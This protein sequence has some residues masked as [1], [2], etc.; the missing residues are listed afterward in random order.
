MVI[1]ALLL[2]CL[3]CSLP[4]TAL[5][6]LTASLDKNP[7]MLGESVTLELTADGR[8]SA[9]SL[10]F[11]VLEQNFTV[12][13][14][15][16]SQST[17]IVNGVSTQQTTWKVV[18][19]P[20]KPG[21]FTIPAF[22]I[23]GI[24]SSALQL[25]VIEQSVQSDA[26]SQE[27]FLQ[28]EIE[29]QEL[30]VQ[31]LSYY[32]VTIYFSGDLQRGSLTEPQLEGASVQQIG[33]DAEGSTLVNGIRYRTITRR[34]GITPQRSGSF[35]ITPP[36]FS[37][38]IIDRDNARYSYFSRTK[39]IVQQAQ[40]LKINV[41]PVPE[42]FPG[43]WLVAGLVT[44]SEEWSA[45][46]DEIMQGEPVTRTITLSAVDVA[47]NQLPELKQSF[48]SGIRLYQEQ[49]QTKAAE[50]NGRLVAQKIFTT[51]VIATDDG[52]IKLPEISLPWWNSQTNQMQ[53]ATLPARTLQVKA[54]ANEPVSVVPPTLPAAVQPQSTTAPDN[55]AWTYTST[56]LAVLWL[57]TL[58]AA[59]II[60]QLKDNQTARITTTG[61]KVRF[62]AG[63]LKKA[64][65]EGDKA[66]AKSELLRFA[67]QQ[68]H[69]RCNSL[70][71]LAALVSSA[72]LKQQLA[73]LNTA[74]YQAGQQPWDGTALFSS[75]KKYASTAESAADNSDLPPLYR[76]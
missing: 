59:Y 15:S 21:S 11:R 3:I 7:A 33:Q 53:Y 17:S 65:T 19:L 14:P 4:A 74:L 52:T 9:D 29:Q 71:E 66:T 6:R 34:Y 39:T 43:S 32:Q 73:R 24:R 20:K 44:L 10:N 60:W 22:S 2:I 18:L 70:S 38:E 26:Q 13:L 48:P 63:K 25:D 72:D 37:G 50:R 23:S 30:Y 58:F 64:C 69:T 67:H 5:T 75:W 35:E 62:D 68:L 49:P 61:S 8:V 12:M 31:Q 36:T 56:L 45:T 28:S 46:P 16:V 47:D 27:L 76:S 1:R 42:Q 55:W 40:P 57:L 41:K 51:A 54:N